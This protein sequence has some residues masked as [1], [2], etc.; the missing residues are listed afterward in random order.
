M[1]NFGW[2]RSTIVVHAGGLIAVHPCRFPEEDSSGSVPD[3]LCQI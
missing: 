3:P 1:S 2:H